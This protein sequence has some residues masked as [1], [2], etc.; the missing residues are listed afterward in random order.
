[1]VCRILIYWSMMLRLWIMVLSWFFSAV[2]DD[3]RQP[4]NFDKSREFYMALFLCSKYRICENDKIQLRESISELI[5]G[6]HVCV[7]SWAWHI[8]LMVDQEAVKG[9][10]YSC[11]NAWAGL[12]HLLAERPSSEKEKLCIWCCCCFQALFGFQEEEKLPA[13]QKW[14]C[15]VQAKTR[16]SRTSPWR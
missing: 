3:G 1:M 16:K 6:K 8:F 11:C 12:G 13:P 15:G 14:L 10:G 4:P 7:S 2:I 9:T 5:P